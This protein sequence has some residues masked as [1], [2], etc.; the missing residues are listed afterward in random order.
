MTHSYDSIHR[1]LISLRGP[2]FQI[3]DG[4][5][6]FLAGGLAAELY[7]LCAFP[8][9]VIKNRMMADSLR[10]PE[11]PTFRSACA[12]VWNAA[13]PNAGVASRIRRVYTGFLPCL[14][15]A[16]PTNAAAIFAFETTMKL[17]AAENVSRR[18]RDDIPALSAC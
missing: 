13:G 10:K 6:T 11:Y 4:L 15:R 16:F 3:S 14:L 2:N 1:Q 7:W 18:R 8:A 9:D 5:C 12:S 17:L